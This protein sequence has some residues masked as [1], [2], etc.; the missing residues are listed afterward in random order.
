M[1]LL[2][3]WAAF[4]LIAVAF[5]ALALAQRVPQTEANVAVF[6]KRFEVVKNAQGRPEM[7]LVK[8]DARVSG[9][10]VEP[11]MQEVAEQVAFAQAQGAAG[12][13]QSFAS[14][15]EPA[16]LAE[17]PKEDRE[18]ARQALEEVQNIDIQ[19]AYKDEKF[20]N[21]MAWLG[22]KLKQHLLGTRVLSN[23]ND[24]RYFYSRAVSRQ[25]VG[26]LV[27]EVTRQ[28][29]N[30]QYAAIAQ[31]IAQ[32]LGEIVQ[33]RRA[34]HQIMLLHYLERF[35][36]EELGMT[37]QEVVRARSSIYESQIPW[38][39]FW[40]SNMAKNH[41]DVYGN[42]YFNRFFDGASEKLLYNKKRYDEV[43][44][45]ADFAFNIV[46]EKGH[47]K[48]INLMDN[49]WMG[50]SRPA[51]A[52]YFDSPM[53]V[54]AQR[55]MLQLIQL[56]IG[57]IPNNHW[58]I[59]IAKQGANAFIDSMYVAHMKTEGALLGYFE[60]TGNKN[61]AKVIR[62]QDFEGVDIE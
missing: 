50:S 37:A 12:M 3:A 24:P 61:A 7:I 27:K 46:T 38:F 26:Y 25:L 6:F 48:V 30:S 20:K 43:G 55:K 39:A 54:L 22:K 21:T 41:W 35:K 40:V 62:G 51:T 18:I 34:Y 17:W 14:T 57:Y 16:E 9:L 29:K 33:D 42:L 23:I 45:R 52:F 44:E 13:E 19:S 10:I 5:P 56:G 4:C 59:L 28:M 32:K 58:A 36:P 49:Q 2:K 60:S 31:F 47:K 8:R 53:R 1:K 15:W 11:F